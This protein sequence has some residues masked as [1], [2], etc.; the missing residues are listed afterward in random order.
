MTSL[1]LNASALHASTERE[2]ERRTIHRSAEVELGP[3]CLQG[4]VEIEQGG[5]A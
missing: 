4:G 5:S 1:L 2:R 3:T